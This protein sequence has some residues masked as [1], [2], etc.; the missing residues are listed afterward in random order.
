M[1]L[2]S[3][4]SWLDRAE[5]AVAGAIGGHRPPSAVEF[6]IDRGQ[7]SRVWDPDGREYLDFLL[8]SGPL[9]LGHAHPAV[10]EA[11][12]RQLERGT[13]FYMANPPAILLAEE[14]VQ[15]AGGTGQVKFVTTGSEATLLALRIARAHTGRNKLLKFE[16]AYHG[17]H[18]AAQ[19]SVSPGRASEYP[20]PLPE[21]A[22]VPRGVQRDVLVAPFNDLVSVTRIV[23]EHASD[24]AAIIVDPQ[25]LGIDP[26]PGFRLAYGGARER[27]G[28]QADLIAYGKIIGGGFPLAA[29]WGPHEIMASVRP[30]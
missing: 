23:T 4:A 1:A 2:S 8:S 21:S 30:R 7:G 13:G 10:M 11:V 26:L 15:A 24:L 27:Y 20:T 18:D 29:V 17:S 16:G 9:I 28:T 3:N 5:R 22:G 19:F 14:I 6:I 12:R 25:V